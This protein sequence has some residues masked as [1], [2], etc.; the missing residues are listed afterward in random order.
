[1]SQRNIETLVKVIEVFN[2]GD[3]EG[4]RS[5]THPELTYVIRGR[6][7]FAGAYRGIDAVIDVMQ[8]IKAAT[9]QTMTAEPE[10]VVAGGDDVMAYLRVHGS[11]PDGRTYDRHQAYLYRFLDG[12]LIEGQTIPV[13]QYAFDEFTRD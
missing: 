5:L 1:M 4:G 6:G 2:T 9:G 8:S 11:R 3:L 7:P 12:L 10:V 13:D